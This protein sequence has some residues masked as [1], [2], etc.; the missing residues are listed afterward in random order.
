MPP[1]K[2]RIV[3]SGRQEEKGNLKKI[4]YKLPFVKNDWLLDPQ[5]L[6]LILQT[7]ANSSRSTKICFLQ[8]E[9]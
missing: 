8:Q 7:D 2:M 9:K 5:P 1:K 3:C 4:F 6:F